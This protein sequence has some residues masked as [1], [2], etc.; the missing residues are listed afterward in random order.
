MKLQ[1]RSLLFGGAGGGG[2]GGGVAADIEWIGNGGSS[3]TG[4]NIQSI[5][6]AGSTVV[7][8]VANRDNV[9]TATTTGCFPS[10]TGYT[11]ADATDLFQNDRFDTGGT[12]D[13]A[14]GAAYYPISVKGS[15]LLVRAEST[16]G[17]YGH[18]AAQ[19]AGTGWTF[20]QL[21]NK[22][23]TSG[24]PNVTCVGGSGYDGILIV[25]GWGNDTTVATQDTSAN[26][27]PTY[28]GAEAGVN[29]ASQQS[30]SGGYRGTGFI[31]F[32]PPS[33]DAITLTLDGSFYSTGG[34]S[35]GGWK[36]RSFGLTRP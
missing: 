16:G 11:P 21:G 1:H 5:A 18:S 33:E 22:S 24:N 12:S 31:G 7:A 10:R 27:S 34:W 26:V 20:T 32:A 15:N 9:A 36:V 25:A 4:W 3:T 30:V 28:S 14:Y 17:G 29:H 19:L 2:G 35:A 6:T 23:G 8:V 13:G